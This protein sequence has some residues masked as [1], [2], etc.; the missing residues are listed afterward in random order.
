MKVDSTWIVHFAKKHGF[1]HVS[2]WR[3]EGKVTVQVTHCNLLNQIEETCQ[4][5][6]VATFLSCLLLVPYTTINT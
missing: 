6:K 1:V 5:L 2:L 3:V 4:I